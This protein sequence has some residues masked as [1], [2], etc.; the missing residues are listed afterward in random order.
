MGM[1]VKGIAEHR[2]VRDAVAWWKATG[3]LSDAD[4]A[5]CSR[6]MQRADLAIARIKERKAKRAHQRH[7]DEPV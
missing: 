1:S 2:I 5:S 4:H 7:G 3:P 6:L